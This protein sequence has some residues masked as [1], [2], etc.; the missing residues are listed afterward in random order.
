[1]FRNALVTSSRRQSRLCYGVA[2]AMQDASSRTPYLIPRRSAAVVVTTTAVFLWYLSSDLVHNDAVHTLPSN[3]GSALSKRTSSTGVD[4]SGALCAVVWGSN[5]SNLIGPQ[6][7][8]I[9]TFQTPVNAKWLENVALRDLALHEKHAACV[10]ARGDVCQ[11]GDGFS[12]S[13]SDVKA[14]KITLRGKNIVKVQLTG[15]RVYALSATGRIYVFA[16]NEEQQQLPKPRISSATSWDL[17]GWTGRERQAIDFVEIFPKERLNWGEK[18]ISIA[19]GSDHLLALTSEGRTYAHPINKDANSHGQLGL[20][21]VEIPAPSNLKDAAGRIAIELVPRS[22]ASPSLRESSPTVASE[23]LNVMDD[24]HIGFSDLLGVKVSQIAAGDRSSFVNTSSGKVL[25][26]GANEHGQIGLGSRITLDTII[27][28]TEIDLAR[29]IPV[30]TKSKCLSIYAGGDLTCFVAE[31][32]AQESHTYVDTLCCGN[33]QWGGLGNNTFSTFQGNPV[34]VRNVSGLHEFDEQKQKLSP[35]IPHA[36]SGVTHRSYFTVSR[37]SVACWPGAS[38]R[39]LV[40]W[41]LN[42]DYQLGTGKRTS[43]NAATILERPEGDRFILGRR[44]ATVRDLSGKVWKNNVEVEQCAIAGH[45][46][47]VVYWKLR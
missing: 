42:H 2:H 1:M 25:G 20:R 32:N 40:A 22:V 29:N 26:W 35:I 43:L 12:C 11:W 37:H 9:E 30:S 17:S 4:E 18:L 24:R 38:G 6:S 23:H 7:P 5:K 16:A 14:P 33:G 28:P 13:K 15:S 10:D 21:R 31:R 44:K 19:A 36:I 3:S 27:I 34:R 8:G 46:N 47:S 41:G 45:G 39:D